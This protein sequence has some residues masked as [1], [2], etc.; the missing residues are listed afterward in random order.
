MLTPL[1][2]ASLLPRATSG[3][4]PRLACVHILFCCL[5]VPSLPFA[6]EV[7]AGNLLPG[8]RQAV[9]P[10]PGLWVPSATAPHAHRGC[11]SG[12]VLCG[13]ATVLPSLQFAI[14]PHLF[15]GP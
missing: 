3:A 12:D 2:E 4:T 1:V 8:S 14:R 15:E 11:P 10:T 13:E 9:K 6:G 7:I 5:D